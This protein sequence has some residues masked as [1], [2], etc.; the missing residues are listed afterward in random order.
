ML[1]RFKIEE[2]KKG[3][4]SLSHGIDLSKTQCP[5]MTDEQEL[6]SKVLYAS[7]IG[8]IMY[9]MISTCPDVSYTPSVTSRY[10]LD[11]GESH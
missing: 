2:A 8:S 10:Q 9:A 3:F 5:M 6:M 7:A 4:L 11:L 1:K